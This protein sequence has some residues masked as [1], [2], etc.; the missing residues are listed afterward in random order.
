[1]GRRQSRC[2]GGAVKRDVYCKSPA[3]RGAI[4]IANTIDR[5]PLDLWVGCKGFWRAC[6]TAGEGVAVELSLRRPWACREYDEERRFVMWTL[7]LL[8]VFFKKAI[9]RGFGVHHLDCGKFS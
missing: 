4:Q 3:A 9:H 1:M 8:F 7:V 6:E 2:E 5:P